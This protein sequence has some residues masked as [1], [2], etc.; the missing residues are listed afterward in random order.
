[1]EGKR[2]KVLPVM[3]SLQVEGKRSMVS[4]VMHLLQVEG[5]RSKVSPVMIG[6]RCRVLTA[7][8]N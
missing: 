8:I 6:K 3:H 4:P 1:M 7:M 5:K 2:S